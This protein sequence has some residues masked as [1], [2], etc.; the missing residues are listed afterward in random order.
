MHIKVFRFL[1]VE[2]GSTD[3]YRVQSPSPGA[4]VQL[5]DL[6]KAWLRA[7]LD[8][9]REEFCKE[10]KNQRILEHLSL[11]GTHKEILWKRTFLQLQHW[12]NTSMCS[13]KS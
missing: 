2:P 1:S 7:F 6:G 10:R 13:C 3:N 8:V 9:K 4:C 5:L 12:A 11:E